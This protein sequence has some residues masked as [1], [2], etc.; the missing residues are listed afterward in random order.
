LRPHLFKPRMGA[1]GASGG[2]RRGR[3]TTRIG[4]RAQP[5]LD[6]RR[7]RYWRWPG[8]L[9]APLTSKS[10]RPPFPSSRSGAAVRR[11]RQARASSGPSHQAMPPARVGACQ[12]R[13]VRG[14]LPV[15]LRV[16][17]G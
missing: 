12:A 16:T 4:I 15:S 3:E 2:R 1:R 8:Q 10:A 11:R 14:R 9:G 5:F 13:C 6:A 7:L 17:G